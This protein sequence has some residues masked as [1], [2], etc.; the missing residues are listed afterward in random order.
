V[1]FSKD[2]GGLLLEL[3]LPLGHQVGVDFVAACLPRLI[4]DTIFTTKSAH[5]VPVML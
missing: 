3:F 1:I 4:A 2:A 5:G